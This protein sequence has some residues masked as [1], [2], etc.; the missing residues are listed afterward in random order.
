MDGAIDVKRVT[1][2]L[3]SLLL[4]SLLGCREE[5]ET[6]TQTLDTARSFYQYYPLVMAA[7]S[8]DTVY[9]MDM[10]SSVIQYVDKATGISGPLCGKPECT[11][12]SE[13]CN[14]YVGSTAR[15]FV[16]GGRLYTVG[17]VPEPVLG[18][19]VYSMALDGTDRRTETYLDDEILPGSGNWPY[20]L[21]HDGVMYYGSVDQRIENGEEV[22]YNHICAFPL[23]EKAEPYDILLE[24]VPYSWDFS[25]QFYGDRLYFITNELAAGTDDRRDFR[26]RRYDV[27]SGE[28]E[29]LYEDLASSAAII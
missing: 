23:D 19:P 1:I 24:K 6:N 5:N 25:M 10:F 17:V 12:D 16:D 22:L 28:I 18:I 21:L 15:M 27:G 20:Y 13:S 26:L 8:E 14:A 2:V 3:F 9:Y 29:T 4:F 11:H 7:E